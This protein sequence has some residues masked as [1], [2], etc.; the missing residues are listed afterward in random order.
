VPPFFRELIQGIK[1]SNSNLE[2][3]RPN[4]GVVGDHADLKASLLR[5]SMEKNEIKLSGK[6]SAMTWPYEKYPRGFCTSQFI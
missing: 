1:N 2:C 4:I 6:N 3:V 5:V